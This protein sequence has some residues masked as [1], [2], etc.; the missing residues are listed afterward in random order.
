MITH[1]TSVTE[2]Q[3]EEAAQHCMSV[4]LSHL[5]NFQVVSLQQMLLMYVLSQWDEIRVKY[6]LCVYTEPRG[7]MLLILKSCATVWIA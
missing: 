1:H 4:T 7:L 3:R 2:L 5:G 6:Q